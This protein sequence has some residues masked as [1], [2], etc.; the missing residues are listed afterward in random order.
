M[1][2]HTVC[3]MWRTLRM[4]TLHFPVALG[5]LYFAGCLPH[6]LTYVRETSTTGDGSGG[7]RRRDQDPD[8]AGALSAR[9]EEGAGAAVRRRQDCA[10]RGGAVET[11]EPA[12]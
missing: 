10:R 8:A 1:R 5:H 2:T 7:V 4:F 9:D 11:R 6:A 12:G 3:V